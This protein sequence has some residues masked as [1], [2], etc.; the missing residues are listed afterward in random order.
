[1]KKMVLCLA[2]LSLL[3]VPA[4]AVCPPDPK[5]PSCT[6]ADVQGYAD[7]TASYQ[8]GCVA[9]KSEFCGI[10]DVCSVE[11][12][13][14]K[15]DFDCHANV[16]TCNTSSNSCGLDLTQDKFEASLTVTKTCG[17]LNE[18]ID[19]KYAVGSN[20]MTNAAGVAFCATP[21]ANA[22]GAVYSGQDLAQS[23][24]TSAVSFDCG[25]ISACNAN[26]TYNAAQSVNLSANNHR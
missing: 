5:D 18:K 7:M 1:M 10:K 17:F 14:K 23:A 11:V 13:C 21:G 16:P 4:F 26:S 15:T 8:A 24:C 19:G 2:I 25:K 20:E 6:G 22:S 9:Q 3:A 12:A